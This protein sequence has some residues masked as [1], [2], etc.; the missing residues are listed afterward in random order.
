LFFI[1]ALLQVAREPFYPLFFSHIPLW[2]NDLP[3]WQDPLVGLPAQVRCCRS[4]FAGDICKGHRQKNAPNQ[5]G[6][7]MCGIAVSFYRVC[8]GRFSA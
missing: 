1:S 2:I 5:S 8:N 7:Q 4:W 6:R 3:D